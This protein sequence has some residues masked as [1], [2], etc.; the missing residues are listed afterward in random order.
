MRDEPPALVWPRLLELP[1]D[2]VKVVYLD[3]NHWISFAQ[4]STGHP[5]GT[6]FLTTLEA[7][8]AAKS[9]GA[10]VFVLSAIHYMEMRKIKDPSQ[11]QAIASVMEELTG[12]ASLVDRNVVM[13]LELDT[14]LD[15]LA[16][17]PSTLPRIPLLG[18]GVRHSFGR[19]SGVRI[20]GPSGDATEEARL[21]MG[22]KAF[23]DFVA[24]A[25]LLLN[26]SVLKGPDDDEVQ[27]LR[28]LGWKPEAATQVAEKRAAQE[29]K[30]TP[31]LDGETSW[32]QG[33]LHDVIS[34]REL[35]IEFEDILPQALSQRHLVLTDVISDRQSARKLAR[36]MP[37]TNVSI[38]L[39][40]AWHRNPDKPWAAN[41]IYDIDAL[42]LA[43][44]YCDIV[45]TEKA[46]HHV[47]N[48][49]RLGERMHTAI[50]RDL[51]HLPSTLEKWK[52]R[53]RFR[54][55]GE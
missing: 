6:S 46:C 10:A 16:Q 35:C 29:Q 34:A 26:R 7:C 23:D 12:F 43:V 52:P 22:A 37:S 24:E 11:R 48:V 5:K 51:E 4:A 55:A 47:L 21:R 13:K 17:E 41:D 27:T 38:E 49:A 28:A 14:M 39:K 20:S 9:A 45:A 50:L 54:K 19:K 44:P 30:L 18:Q 36:A 15:P 40:T 33:R 1:S 25:E 53:R 42:S 31:M 8:R 2:D 3:L 32:R